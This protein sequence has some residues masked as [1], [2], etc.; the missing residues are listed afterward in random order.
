MQ[1][2]Y[3]RRYR[4]KR[5]LEVLQ[6][7]AGGPNPMCACCPEGHLEFLTV[8]H[9]NGR[10]TDHKRRNNWGGFIASGDALIRK[11]VQEGLPEG[12]QILCYNCNCARGHRGR[13]GKCPHQIEREEASREQLLEVPI[14]EKVGVKA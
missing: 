5:R 9:I 4:L 7:Y 3:V 2:E 6:H 8:D 1:A 10:S 14:I 12:Y 13:E 11:L